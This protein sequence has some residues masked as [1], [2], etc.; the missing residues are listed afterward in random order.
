[1]HF[2]SNDHKSKAE[3]KAWQ[4][5]C[6]NIYRV[7]KCLSILQKWESLHYSNENMGG[8]SSL[9]VMKMSQCKNVNISK[10]QKIW[11]NK[12]QLNQI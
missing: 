4:I 10:T 5:L 6:L 12:T 9:A 2:N 7:Y 11:F 8:N 3:I 1:M